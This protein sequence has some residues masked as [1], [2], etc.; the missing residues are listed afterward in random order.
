MQKLAANTACIT[1]TAGAMVTAAT[2]APEAEPCAAVGGVDH[3]I[4]DV[5]DAAAAPV[6]LELDQKRAGGD[7]PCRVAV[8]A[9][10]DELS[11]IMRWTCPKALPW[12]AATAG[13]MRACHF[14][15]IGG[16]FYHDDV[17][18]WLQSLYLLKALC[19]LDAQHWAPSRSWCVPSCTRNAQYLQVARDFH[20]LSQS[21]G[22]AAAD[23]LRHAWQSGDVHAPAVSRCCIPIEAVQRHC[24]GGRGGGG[25]Q[26]SVSHR[27]S[28]LSFAMCGCYTDLCQQPQG[29]TYESRRVSP[30]VDLFCRAAFFFG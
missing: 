26:R 29:E 25:A 24:W 6:Q 9:R 30:T 20:R 10:S 1:C 14:H 8:C 5:P 12:L 11:A 28:S 17:V 2:S 3:H 18:V 22:Q 21:A 15:C 16:T 7:D 23:S 4:L 13:K 27:L 19:T